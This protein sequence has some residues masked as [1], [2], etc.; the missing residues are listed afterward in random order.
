MVASKSH[1]IRR[2]RVTA[3]EILHRPSL[4]QRHGSCCRCQE[5]TRLSS[6]WKRAHDQASCKQS[7]EC[8][9]HQSRTLRGFSYGVCISHI[10]ITVTKY[11]REQKYSFCSRLQGAVTEQLKLWQIVCSRSSLCCERPGSRKNSRDQEPGYSFKVCP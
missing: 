9:K 1:Q 5:S 6:R 8:L 10:H 11:L 4:W 2:G 7:N 3:K